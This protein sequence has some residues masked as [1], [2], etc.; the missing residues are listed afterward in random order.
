MRGQE[1][2]EVEVRVVRQLHR[3]R[4][5]FQA[6]A[7][8][9]HGVQDANGGRRQA[10]QGFPRRPDHLVL[11]RGAVLLVQ[12]HG[13]RGPPEGPLD[14]PVHR[15]QETSK[16]LLLRVRDQQRADP[17]VES[18]RSVRERR[19]QGGG[20]VPEREVRLAVFHHRQELPERRGQVA[21]QVP[22][23]GDQETRKF[24]FNMIFY[25]ASPLIL[26][27]VGTINMLHTPGVDSKFDPRVGRS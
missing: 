22:D 2:C 16:K 27:D 6:R 15:A 20:V 4:A 9:P 12:V 24:K 19:G 11:Q 10:G 5:A 23:H 8:Q 21:D 13:G 3:T 14:L 17:E 1:V 7:R 26:V 18:Y 25:F